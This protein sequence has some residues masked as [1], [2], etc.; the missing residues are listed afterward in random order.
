MELLKQSLDN[1]ARSKKTQLKNY[2][3]EVKT[4][5]TIDGTYAQC[6]IHCINLDGNGRPLIEGIISYL[7]E[8]IL[9][10]AIPRSHINEAMKFFQ[11]TGSTSKILKLGKQANELFTRLDKSG[12][13]GEL[14]L[15]ALAEHFL[16]LPQLIC[17]MNLKT[18]SEMHFHGADGL[19][20][21]V[22]VD[23]KK[24]C[25]Y[26]GESKL[27]ADTAAA[28]NNC[29]K[30]LGP[31][32]NSSGASGSSSSRDLQLLGSYLDVD[33]PELERALKAYLDPS[34]EDFLKVQY[35][36][37]CLV[38]FDIDCYPSAPNEKTI[39]EVQ[40]A[41]SSQISSWQKLV[42][43]RLNEESLTKFYIHIFLLPFP[44]VDV[45]RKTFKNALTGSV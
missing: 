34:N 13:G 33:D 11:E 44:S 15:F 31:I 30:S 10:Y 17:K 1:L 28:I 3:H 21:G 35:R 41:I 38:G 9:D 24:F 22:D 19:H 18:S 6:H 45:F 16:K 39:E 8:L 26:W 42:T 37:L 4:G 2:F 27:Y 5:V 20:A 36:G 43:K 32:L 12:E 25:L 23:T 29:M 7:I 14:L 40:D